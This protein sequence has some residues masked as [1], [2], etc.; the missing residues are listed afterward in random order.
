MPSGGGNHP[1]KCLCRPA[2]HGANRT[3]RMFTGDASA[4]FLVEA[5]YQVGFASQPSSEHRTP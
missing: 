2:A 1:I 3:G 5:L 4:R